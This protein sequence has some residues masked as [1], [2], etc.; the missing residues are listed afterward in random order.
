MMRLPSITPFWAPPTLAGTNLY[1]RDF[2]MLVAL[3]LK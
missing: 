3:D 2:K 1:L